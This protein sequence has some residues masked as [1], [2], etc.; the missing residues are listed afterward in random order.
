M[1]D[2]EDSLPPGLTGDIDPAPRDLLEFLRMSSLG[3]GKPR[4]LE[5][6]LTLSLALKTTLSVGPKQ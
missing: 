1:A 3:A 2:L 5:E 4:E 6:E